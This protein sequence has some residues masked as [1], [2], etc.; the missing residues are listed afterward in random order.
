MD[1]CCDGCNQFLSLSE[2]GWRNKA[3]AN[4]YLA[5]TR[6][7]ELFAGSISAFI[8]QKQG[9]RK[10]NVLATVGLGAVVFSIFLYDETTPFPS[11]YAL[12]PIL[13]VVLLI[14]HADKETFVAKLLSTRGFVGIGLISYSA[15]LWHQPLFA[16]A[17]VKDINE[18]SWQTYLLLSLGAIGL[19]FLSWNY[20]E[21]PFRKRDVVSTRTLFKISFTGLFAFIC[22]GITLPKLD[23]IRLSTQQQLIISDGERNRLTMKKLAYDR[24][25]C[26]FD[27]S[28][29][30]S[31]LVDMGCVSNSEKPRIILFGDSEAAHLYEGMQK[32]FP[33]KHVMQFTG[34][35]CRA[36]DYG[37]NSDRCTRFYSLFLSEIIPNLKSDDII[38]VSSNWW[39]TF[40]K[41][42]EE[43]F[44]FSLKRI[45]AALKEKTRNVVVFTNA[46][47]FLNNPYETLAITLDG[48]ANKRVFLAS[49]NIWKS[50]FAIQ[51]VAA[52]VGVGAF[53]AAAELCESDRTCLFKDNIDYLYFDTG[54]FSYYGSEF[55]SKKF[56]DSLSD[57]VSE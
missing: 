2:W 21:K 6:A 14:L 10:N 15:Y 39:N 23:M 28:Q 57:L 16:F 34:T 38:V 30:A 27:Y 19:A 12:V 9:I 42:G 4:F 5:P 18:P 36:I 32:A 56:S 22:I 51:S 25:G 44:S 35:S 53:N 13:G 43:E 20:I 50:D 49:Q 52:D 37:K 31:Q 47:G 7:W 1:D 41:I 24:Y 54:H 8:V 17:R 29:D 26:F 46:P 45:L 3:S 33:N 55:I 11:V 40:E 48:V